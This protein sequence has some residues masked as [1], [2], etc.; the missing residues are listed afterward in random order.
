MQQECGIKSNRKRTFLNKYDSTKNTWVLLFKDPVSGCV[1]AFCHHT[2][3]PVSAGWGPSSLR[4]QIKETLSWMKSYTRTLFPPLWRSVHICC[5][6]SA[7]DQGTGSEFTSELTSHVWPGKD[8]GPDRNLSHCCCVI[9]TTRGYG[10]CLNSAVSALL[11]SLNLLNIWWESL[12]C[13]VFLSE[14]QRSS[15]HRLHFVRGPGT[16]GLPGHAAYPIQHHDH[17]QSL[18]SAQG[19]AGKAHFSGRFSK[20]EPLYTGSVQI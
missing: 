15:W 5:S 14:T 17:W 7:A 8:W 6:W 12:L 20:Y 3:G 9:I 4:A 18:I 16:W 1:E 19:C 13:F 2:A 11:I 10:T